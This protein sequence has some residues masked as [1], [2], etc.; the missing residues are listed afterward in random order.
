M[1]KR[2]TEK[3]CGTGTPGTILTNYDQKCKLGEQ[4]I[5]LNIKPYFFICVY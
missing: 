3:F 1:E 4:N 5:F 2:N